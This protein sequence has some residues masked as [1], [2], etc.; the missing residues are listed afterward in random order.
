MIDI[1]LEK[2]IKESLKE[3]IKDGD[4]TTLACIDKNTTNSAELIAKDNGVIAGIEL[5]LLIFNDVDKELD[6]K[7]KY[8]DGDTVRNGDVIMTITGNSH[9]ILTAERLVLNCMQKMSAIASKTRH[10]CNLISETN[11]KVLDTRKTTP[12]NRKIQKWAVKIGGGENHRNGLY[13]MIMIKDNHI[14]FS[15]GITNAIKKTKDYLEKEDKTL[16]IIVETRNIDEVKEVIKEGGIRRILLD[17][18]NYTDTRKA[19]K[20]IDN[21]FETESSGGIDESNILEYAKCG[22]DY[23]SL[24]SLTHTIKNFDLSL[25]AI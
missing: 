18:F 12:L 16:D 25:K 11:A 21:K 20:I 23:I 4:H 9:S 14:D 22:V 7:T 1:E 5:A 24:G 8:N 10:I 17:N 6:I 13:D 15:K 3:D 2:F 19:V